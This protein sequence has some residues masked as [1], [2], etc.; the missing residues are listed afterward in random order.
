[1]TEA[2]V[3]L[4]AGGRLLIP[5]ELRDAMGIQP[6]DMLVLILEGDGLRVLTPVQAV[7]RARALVDRY[8]A[9]DRELAAELLQERKEER[10]AP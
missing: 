3:K 10:G 7:A 6:G 1:M 9:P 4:G 8:V 2:A 5:G